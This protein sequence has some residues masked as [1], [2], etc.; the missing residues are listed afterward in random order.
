MI[1]QYPR[2]Q[3]SEATKVAIP[4][5]DHRRSQEALSFHPGQRSAVHLHPSWLMHVCAPFHG[6]NVISNS[7]RD[8]GLSP[9]HRSSHSIFVSVDLDYFMGSFMEC[10]DIGTFQ[11]P[12]GFSQNKLAHGPVVSHSSCNCN[13]DCNFQLTFDTLW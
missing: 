3:H 12:P 6:N 11:D 10:W 7:G 9:F 4:T 2:E 5:W 1:Y 13:D 8:G